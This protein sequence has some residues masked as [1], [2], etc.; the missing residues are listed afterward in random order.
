MIVKLAADVRWSGPHTTA[1]K[2]LDHTYT[3]SS[4]WVALASLSGAPIVP[5]FCRMDA[6]G[7]YR[8]EFL[9]SFRIPAGD[10]AP[11]GTAPEFAITCSPLR[12]AYES[13][14]PTATTI[15]SGPTVRLNIQPSPAKILAKGPGAAAV[16]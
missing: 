8:L 13:T 12:I 7:R 10:A 15:S 6:E 1:V 4:T 2:F 9:P 16:E 11:E 14:L 5:V 3:F